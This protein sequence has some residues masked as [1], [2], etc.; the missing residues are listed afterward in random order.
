MYSINSV[1]LFMSDCGSKFCSACDVGSDVCSILQ[2]S[3]QSTSVNIY[4]K[5]NSSS[6]LTYSYFLAHGCTYTR[7]LACH[8]N[9]HQKI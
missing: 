3:V 9:S 1:A 6:I 2:C 8:L 4:R 7:V 5:L